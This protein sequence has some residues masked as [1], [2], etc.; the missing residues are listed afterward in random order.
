[1]ACVRDS[2]FYTEEFFH[3]KKLSHGAKMFQKESWHRS[4]ACNAENEDRFLRMPGIWCMGTAAS[5]DSSTPLTVSDIHITGYDGEGET[6]WIRDGRNLALALWHYAAVKDLKHVYYTL[7]YYTCSLVCDWTVR[8][9]TSM[10][11][12]I[13]NHTL[14]IRSHPDEFSHHHLLKPSQLFLLSKGMFTF[15]IANS[16]SS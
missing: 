15:Y 6:G 11:I 7:A 12:Q 13:S 10:F 8:H 2:D 9:L 3:F 14:N 16:G 5:S 1:M 4:E